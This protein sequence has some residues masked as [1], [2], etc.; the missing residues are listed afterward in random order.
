MDAS[1]ERSAY[2]CL[3]LN[4]ANAHGWEIL[5]TD[6]LLGHLGR[7]AKR[8]MRCGSSTRPGTVAPAVSHFGERHPD[9]PRPLPVQD[10]SGRRPV[11]DRSD[12]PAKDGIAPLT[13]VVE[14]DWSPY[15]FTMNWLFTRATQRIYFEADEPFCHVFPVARRE[16]ES[17]EP[18]IAK[19]SR[20]SRLESEH[21]AWV[22]QPQRIQRRAF[23]TRLRRGAGEVAEDLFQREISL[24]PGRARRPPEQASAGAVQ[25]EVSGDTMRTAFLAMVS[26][27]AAR[28]PLPCPIQPRSSA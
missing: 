27:L 5:C 7:A 4:I 8:S 2:R 16:I 21:K 24:R 19:L 22:G 13:G 20:Q 18:R 10:R 14:T 28:L 11:R 26:R 23:K 1:D 12:Q 25:A 17:L 9:V 3:P 6:Q 15:T